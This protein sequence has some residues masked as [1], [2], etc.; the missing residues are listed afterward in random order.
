MSKLPKA[1]LQE[2]IFEIR[3]ALK[4]DK[5]SGQLNDEGFEFA[6]GRLSTI[7]ENE[8]PVIKR[9]IP[10]DIPSQ[11]MHYRVINQYWSGESTWPVIQLGPGIFT[12]NCTDDN[13]FWEEH[14]R[15]LIDKGLDCLEQAYKVPLSIEYVSLRYIDAITTAE[16][17]LPGESWENFIKRNFNLEYSNNFNTRG[18]QKQIKINQVF[19]LEDKSDLQLEITNG[20]IKNQDALIW[21]TSIS[22]PGKFDKQALIPWADYAHGVTHDLFKELVKPH[23]YASFSGTNSN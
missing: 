3:W 9:I 2:V 16:H 21:Q 1:P 11:L 14:F 4:P 6:G 5:I 15:G 13:Y 12:I 23:L 17:I 8:F 10:A 7:L 19:E 22:K 20:K 18:V